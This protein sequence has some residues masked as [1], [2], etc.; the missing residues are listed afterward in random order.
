MMRRAAAGVGEC[1]EEGEGMRLEAARLTADH[2]KFCRAVWNLS[3][4]HPSGHGGTMLKLHI[5]AKQHYFS[6]G[7]VS[8]GPLSTVPHRSEVANEGM[9]ASP[10]SLG[11][12]H[13]EGTPIE[14]PCMG[15]LFSSPAGALVGWCIVVGL[16]RYEE[17]LGGG[18]RLEVAVRMSG[19]RRGDLGDGRG[20]E[21]QMV[22]AD[23]VRL[24]IQETTVVSV[25]CLGRLPGLFCECG[26]VS[27]SLTRSATRR[28]TFEACSCPSAGRTSWFAA[29]PTSSCGR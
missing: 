15:A 2:G 27:P 18:R 4:E 25:F 24:A 26:R 1:S 14:V 7:S 22:P 17:A 9:A 5:H 11:Q 19:G 3:K 8:L 29:C 28:W 16:P 6:S 20:D 13:G 21:V 23:T 10:C 12:L